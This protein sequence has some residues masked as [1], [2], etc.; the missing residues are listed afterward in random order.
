MIRYDQGDPGTGTRSPQM[1]EVPKEALPF[2]VVQTWEPIPQIPLVNQ[3][4]S[5]SISNLSSSKLGLGP[6]S[7]I[8]DKLI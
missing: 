5:E 1:P 7:H 2:G 4:L 3:D 6:I 8:S